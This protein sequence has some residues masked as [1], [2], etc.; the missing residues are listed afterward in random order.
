M[1]VKKAVLIV[2][3]C[4]AAALAS[5]ANP[6]GVGPE[7]AAPEDMGLE[8]I[9]SALA[10]EADLSGVV[11]VA[12]GGNIMLERAYTPATLQGAAPV[13]TDSRFAIA[14]MTMTSSGP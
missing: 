1:V 3:V 11:L 12:S 6:E 2:L 9:V 8:E 13:G 10:D 14:S 5:C 4:A 7:G